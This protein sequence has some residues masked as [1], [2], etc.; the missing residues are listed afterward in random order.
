M[1]DRERNKS[2]IFG[3]IFL[4]FLCGQIYIF[5]FMKDKYD[6]NMFGQI[7]C[8]ILLFVFTLS[9]R[10]KMNWNAKGLS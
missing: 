10:E 7:K 5:M 3:L 2:L 6:S 1:V 8:V 4:S 9:V